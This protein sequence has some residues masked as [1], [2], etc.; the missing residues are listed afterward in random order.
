MR[1]QSSFPGSSTDTYKERLFINSGYH[2]QA[3]RI[4][5]REQWKMTTNRPLSLF[6]SSKMQELAHERRHI[7]AVLKGYEIYGWLWE[8]DAGARPEP[9]R[10]TYLEEV[11]SCDIYIGLFWLGYGPDTIEEYKHARIYNKPCLIYEKQVNIEKR[12]PE[13]ATFLQ[14]IQQVANPDGLTVYHF[15]TS[16]QLAKQVHTDVL[17]LLTTRFRENRQQPESST[18]HIWNVPFRH[19]PFFTGRTNL[20]QQLLNNLTSYKATALTQA[21]VINGLGGIGKTQIALEYAY[22]FRDK[23]QT[24]LWVRAATFDTL[25]TD[26]VTLADLLDLP[27]KNEQDQ[28]ITVVAV[29]RWLS[30]YHNWLLILDNVEDL[31][32]VLEFLPINGNGHILLTTRLQAVGSLAHSLEVEKMEMEEGI[33]LLLRRAKVLVPDAMLEQ[34]PQE[35]LT[36]AKEV[37]MVM[38]GLPLALDQAGAYIEETRCSLSDYLNLYQTQRVKLLNIRG[39]IASDHPESVATT[40]SLAFEKV[41]ETNA[42]AAN[43]LRL[44]AF[45]NPDMIPEEI[46]TDYVPNLDP[47]LPPIVTD[48]FELNTVISSILKFS[49]VRRNRDTKPLPLHRLIQAVIKHG[50]TEPTQNEWAQHAVRAVSR[51]FPFA[52]PITWQKCQRF[53]PHAY[54]CAELIERYH[55]ETMEATGLLYRIARYLDDRALYAEANLY[56]QRALTLCEKLQGVEYPGLADILRQL[57]ELHRVQ[58]KYAQAE[59]LHQRALKIRK[60]SSGREEL[61]LATS[62]DDLAGLYM[63]QGRYAQAESYYLRALKIRKKVLGPKHQ[64]VGAILNNL[65]LLKRH[66]DK[67][68]EAEALYQQSLA[69]KKQNAEDIDLAS[70]LS[71]LADLY[72]AQGKYTEAE[73]LSHQ[74][75]TIC[76]KIQG[77]EHPEV[78]TKINNLALIYQEQ[79]KDTEAEALHLRALANNENVLGANH[80]KVAITLGNLGALYTK[81]GKYEQAEL[82]LNRAVAINEQMLGPAHPEVANSLNNLALC[83]VVQGKYDLAEPL[84]RQ[85]LAIWEQTSGLQPAKMITTLNNLAFLLRI[86]KREVE[87]KELDMK[88]RAMEAGIFWENCR[89]DTVKRLDRFPRGKQNTRKSKKRAH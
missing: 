73:A 31:N 81:Q 41:Q 77:L 61:D 69:M 33:L 74:A 12:S 25:I 44:C 8:E 45:L 42:S 87:A 1:K 75:L 43:L 46:F 34:A 72:R 24:V 71:N 82:L 65:A 85:A 48:H 3:K 37:A 78:A 88:A 64:Q 50:M 15:E 66:Q 84:F 86:M 26:Y 2:R 4:Y 89:T 32:L 60:N 79:G 35:E 7:Q 30:K 80:P 10:N 29:K 36:K 54:V 21:E 27:E 9:I 55:I 39:N 59:T 52:S 17:R 67:Y 63:E 38:D 70:N 5:K 16:E 40:F 76:E 11:H 51:S 58:G 49:L 53:L 83:Y 19:N 18:Q 14:A 68:A 6:I 28:N 57:A 22:R 56:Y 47:A 62:F 13:L 23:Y 20:L